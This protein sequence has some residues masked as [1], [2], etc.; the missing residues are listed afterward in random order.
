M[1]LKKHGLGRDL[2]QNGQ[3]H[4]M[5]APAVIFIFIMCYL[6]M[7]GIVLAFKN[8]RY[9]LGIFGSP[10]NGFDNFR[11]L[12]VSGIGWRITR[13]T[14]VF[15][16]INIVSGHTI[17]ILL[18]L[19][20]A[21]FPGGSFGKAYKRF[22]QSVSFLPHFISWVLVGVF[23]YNIFSYD[24]GA[25]NNLLKTM[26]FDPVN[27]YQMPRAWYFIIPVFNAWKW[28]GWASIIYIASI[29]AI[30]QE[31]YEAADIDG[32]NKFQK[33]WYITLPSIKPTIIIMLLLNLGNILR[34][35]FEMFYQLVGNNGQLF[36]VTEIIDTYVFRSLMTNPSLGMTA[37]ASVYQSV[38]CFVFIVTINR[39]VRKVEPDYALF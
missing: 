31:C 9:D 11:F 7:A 21:E 8:F 22:C 15:N 30:D 25:L 23:A 18:A 34:G 13:N 3:L 26:G 16:L 4:V 6:P 28:C 33:I 24:I 2:A 38:V 35:N 12:F 5:V 37:A 19:A 20:I 29:M 39:I 17:A 1:Q 10:W 36:P 27:I 32:A 14:I